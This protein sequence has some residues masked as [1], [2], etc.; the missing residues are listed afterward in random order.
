MNRPLVLFDDDFIDFESNQE[1]IKDGKGR[2]VGKQGASE[3]HSKALYGASRFRSPS[4]PGVGSWCHGPSRGKGTGRYHNVKGGNHE[5]DAMVDLL[6]FLS[7]AQDLQKDP[8]GTE[9]RNGSTHF[10]SNRQGYLLCLTV[11]HCR[12]L[13]RLCKWKC[14]CPL[15]FTRKC[16]RQD[17]VDEDVVTVD[18]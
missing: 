6:L 15:R 14:R 3:L 1:N 8:Q 17:V 4:F 13:W 16:R 2:I 7:T 9:N 18:W 10:G 12:L 5:H 11:T